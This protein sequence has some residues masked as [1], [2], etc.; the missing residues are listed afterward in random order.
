MPGVARPV[1]MPAKSSLATST[2]FSIFS[3]ASSRVSSI[4]V[5]SFAAARR[6]RLVVFVG[7]GLT[8]RCLVW[9]VR[10]RSGQSAV[11]SVPIFSP[12]MARATLPSPSMPNTTMGSLFSMHRLKAAASTTRSPC[13]RASL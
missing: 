7:S 1:R 11:T 5:G 2:A 6:P 3:S 4:I 8:D 9:V 10:C 12:R 13:C